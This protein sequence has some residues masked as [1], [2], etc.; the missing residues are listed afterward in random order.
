M[1]G[2]R[3]EE[4]GAYLKK[5]QHAAKLIGFTALVVAMSTWTSCSARGVTKEA[6]TATD[7]AVALRTTATRFSQQFVAAS[8][9]ETDEWARTT[10]EAAEFGTAEALKVSLA[11]TVSRIAEVA[12]MSNA[13]ASFAPADSLGLAGTRI[14]GDLTFQPASFG[15]KLEASGTVSSVSRVILRLPPATEITSLSIGGDTDDLKATFQLAVY[16]SGEGP[17]N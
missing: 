15:L 10:Q 2:L 3:L 9:G 11:Q 13:K 17:Q 8:T 5:N 16:Q 1:K 7:E 4:A 14:I 12:G 6:R